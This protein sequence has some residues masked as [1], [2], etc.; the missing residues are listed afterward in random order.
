[1]LTAALYCF[2]IEALDIRAEGTYELYVGR[3]LA[4]LL[5]FIS[6]DWEADMDELQQ[7]EGAGFGLLVD[8]R[9]L[10]AALQAHLTGV[11]LRRARM[12][13]YKGTLL[14]MQETLAVSYRWHDEDSV[15]LAA[16]SPAWD[17][18]GEGRSGD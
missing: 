13:R 6:R 9:R 11:P 7:P 18:L 1:M 14:R 15:R 12:P 8:A 3:V 4:L 16:P 17:W 10:A 5:L 2:S